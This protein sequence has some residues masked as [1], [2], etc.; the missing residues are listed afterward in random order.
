MEPL[1][2]RTSILEKLSEQFSSDPAKA[3]RIDWVITG[4]ESGEKARE[5]PTDWYRSL[6]AECLFAGTPFF[7]KQAPRGAEG[8]TSGEGSWVKLKDGIIE[9]PYLDGVQHIGFPP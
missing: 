7:L 3:F 4:C 5:T 9:Q 1:I 6:R 2:E 8:I